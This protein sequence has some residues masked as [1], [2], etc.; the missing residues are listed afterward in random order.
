[1]EPTRVGRFSGFLRFVGFIVATVST[2]AFVAALLLLLLVVLS[3][4]PTGS[5]TPPSELAG[6]SA[7]EQFGYGIGWSI[8]SRLTKPAA[9]ILSGML[10]TPALIGGLFGWMLTGTKKVY[11]CMRC[12]F[13][14]DRA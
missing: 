4:D 9:F 7:A 5:T 2:L 8:G 1:M 11:R 6:K 10:G 3:S 14:L 13:V 12:G